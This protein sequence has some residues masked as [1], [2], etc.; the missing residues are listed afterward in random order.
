MAFSDKSMI[1]PALLPFLLVMLFY[2]LNIK[3]LAHRKAELKVTK[4]DQAS[5]PI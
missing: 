1:L 2:V 5:A 3:A 4:M